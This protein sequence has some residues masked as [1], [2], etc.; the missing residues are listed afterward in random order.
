VKPKTIVSVLESA[1]AANDVALTRALS[2]AQWYESD[3]HVLDVRPSSRV[4]DSGRD[5]IRNG[6]V[7]RI[8]VAAHASGARG[9]NITP[10][11][12]SGS[13]VRAIADYTGRV[14][15]DLVVVGKQARR[16]NGYWSAGSFAAALG[17]AVKAPTIA[18][19]S[20]RARPAESGTP[21]RNILSAVDFSE[22]SFR[23]LSEALAL[24]QQ[25]GGHLTLLHVVEGFPSETVYS[26][27]RAFRLMHDF[28]ARVARV[29]RELQSLIPSDAYNW[30]E[31]EVATVSGEAHEAIL[32]AASER[33]TDL[34]VLGLP[35]RPRLEQFVAGST[36]HRVLRRATSPV[37]L[38]P[39]PA[40]ASLFRPAD[41]HDGQL[42]RYPSALGLRA[43]E[44]AGAT[45]G[46]AENVRAG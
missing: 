21:F 30:S 11:V 8:T 25:S 4:E 19:P 24:A 39:G 27:S 43:V 26:G 37:L 44:T 1:P 9:V 23:A 46:T 22:V 35:R 31:I 34:I 29:N 42:A 40:T 38:V 12:L 14:A 33:R 15:A 16:R 6:L 36:V 2:L 18:I 3:L 17:R 7:E 45:K 32:G 5:A 28:R 10:S 41:E 20:E 13:P